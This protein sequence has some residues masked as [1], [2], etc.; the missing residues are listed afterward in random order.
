M[1]KMSHAILS[2]VLPCIWIPAAS[3]QVHEHPR[4][5]AMMATIGKGTPIAQA[6]TV[7]F[8]WAKREMDGV[9]VFF[10]MV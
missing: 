3:N 6:N 7:Q 4:I 8:I 5:R 10:I 2:I 1:L 9:R